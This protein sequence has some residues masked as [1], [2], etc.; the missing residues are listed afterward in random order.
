[1]HPEHDNLYLHAL[2]S[3]EGIGRK[4]LLA[5]V[6]HFGSARVAWNAETGDLSRVINNEK[7]LRALCSMRENTDIPQLH[8]QLESE[9]IR[10]LSFNDT[11]YPPLLKEI[12]DYPVLLYIRGSIDSVLQRP[13]IAVVGTRKPTPYGQQATRTIVRELAASGIIII[14]G[15]AIGLDSIAHET[16]VESNGIT[17]GVLG[18]GIAD[19]SI[20]PRSHIHLAHAIIQKGGAIVSEYSPDMQAGKGTFPARNRIIAGLSVGALVIEASSGSGSLITAKSAL[21]YNRDV[22]AVPGSIFSPASE[23]TNTLL[24]QG[25]RPVSC[26]QDIFDALQFSSQ[27]QEISRSARDTSHLSAEDRMILVA[28]ENESLTID[29]LARIT[30]LSVPVIGSRITFLELEGFVQDTGNG[31]YIYL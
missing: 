3:V 29:A 7:T 26:A 21:E 8:A 30:H 12:Y 22:F 20:T 13:T 27:A 1:M 10:I 25:A 9:H 23:G 4:T 14:S 28:L 5:L 6:E 11:E 19:K 31:L 18:S 17:I 24:K 16:A 15:L 2:N